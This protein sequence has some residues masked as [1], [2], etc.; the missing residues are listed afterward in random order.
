MKALRYPCM[1][2][3]AYVLAC[4]L[5][6][7]KKIPPQY[8]CNTPVKTVTVYDTT[9]STLSFE[10]RYTYDQQGRVDSIIDTEN[11]GHSTGTLTYIM[12]YDAQNHL[13]N[14]RLIGLANTY[15][16]QYR[17]VNGLI[18]GI[19]SSLFIATNYAYTFRRNV[20]WYTGA[21]AGL[22]ISNESS[23]LKEIAYF[24]N[25]LHPAD[26]DS[27]ITSARSSNTPEESKYYYTYS[28]Q[29]NPEYTAYNNGWFYAYSINQHYALQYDPAATSLHLPSS[30]HHALLYQLP[31]A[32]TSYSFTKDRCGRVTKVYATQQGA[33][34][35]WKIYTYY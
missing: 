26:P 22:L 20:Q 27:I 10:R 30:S 11:N 24:T 12:T 21:M 6:S 14:V 9:N 19:S 18:S 29:L 3:M 16:I 25:T 28:N 34:K 15:D 13:T 1:L 35:L 5:Y 32:V 4:T 8:V 7:C 23:K 2:L 17:S 33:Q 31:S